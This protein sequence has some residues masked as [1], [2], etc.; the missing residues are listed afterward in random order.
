[1]KKEKITSY[2]YTLTSEEAQ[3]FAR[4]LTY[5][6]HRIINHNKDGGVASLERIEALLKEFNR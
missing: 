5:I 3:I 6:R 1:M 2:E 4:A